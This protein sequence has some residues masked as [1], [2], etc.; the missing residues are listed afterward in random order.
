MEPLHIK[1]RP[2]DFGEVVGQDA[3]VKS[4][5]H[6]LARDASH[7]FLFTGPSGVGKTTLARIVAA[8]IK[9]Q[10]QDLLEIDAAT[11]TGIDDM[12]E[13][14][15]GLNYRPLGDGAVKVI[16]VDE[17]HMLSKSAWNSMLKVLEEPPDWVYWMLCTTEPL[18]VPASIK[19]RCL[20]YDLKPVALMQLIEL[21]DYVVGSEGL[22]K[23]KEGIV[24]LCA[25][26]ADGS[27]RQALVNLATCIGA[28]SVSQARELLRSAEGSAEA[29]ELA[30]LLVK[31]ATW[32][33]VQALLKQLS[34]TSPE[35]IR[36][37][38]RAYVTKTVLVSKREDSA[39]RGLAVLDAFSEPFH[40]SDGI[41][42]VVLACGRLLLG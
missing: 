3:V 38:V 17:C 21:L 14:T 11:N 27:P 1:Y 13:V 24:S 12:R 4:L 2:E 28:G 15:S 10:P 18:R 40:P 30:Q 39:G 23:I 34:D 41:T 33:Q 16:I 35:S 5:K 7:T 6:A 19:T 42:P 25:K 9:C 36:Q 37:V 22:V 32:E 20:A 31:G 29:F 8:T 26:E